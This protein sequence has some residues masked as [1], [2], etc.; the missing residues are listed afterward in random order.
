MLHT[1]FLKIPNFLN[2]EKH[3]ALRTANIDLHFFFFL[4][5]L[6]KEMA[7]HFS[8]LAWRIPGTEEPSRLQSMGL[9]RIGHDC[10]DL[11][12][13][14]A[15]LFYKSQNKTKKT[16]IM[17]LLIFKFRVLYHQQAFIKIVTSGQNC[18]F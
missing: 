13:A 6:A 5:L 4:L 10:S 3:I 15:A 12:A 7:T 18:C 11:A 17:N 16:S 8:V 14:A 9:H 2:S 1:A